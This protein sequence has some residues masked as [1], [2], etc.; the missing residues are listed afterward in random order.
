MSWQQLRVRCLTMTNK[1]YP[2][3]GGRGIKVCDRWL[4]F[5]N[6]LA[7]MGERPP[8]TSI[9]RIDNN[10]NYEPGNC[11]WAT[12]LEQGRNRR[13]ARKGLQRRRRMTIDEASELLGRFEHGESMISIAKRLNVSYECVRSAVSGK[14]W[15]VLQPVVRFA[16]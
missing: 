5:E 1:A 16:P 10:G 3:Y 4:V 7:D 13:P 8:G 12:A 14:N 11:R 15:R 6:F 2:N 9:D